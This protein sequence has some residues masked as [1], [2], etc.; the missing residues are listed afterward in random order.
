MLHCFFK[1]LLDSKTTSN[2]NKS[3]N[4][5]GSLNSSYATSHQSI[6][7]KQSIDAAISSKSPDALGTLGP[8]HATQVFFETKSPECG[9]DEAANN[10]PTST[11]AFAA[12]WLSDDNQVIE[13][14]SPDVLATIGQSDETRVYETE[15]HEYG[16][17]SR[18]DR[19]S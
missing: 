8:S 16:E 11:G 19:A 10:S 5:L 1:S 15:S 4:R 2:L 9:D 14:I 7:R 17:L 13:T 3:F 18:E 6:Q 12:R